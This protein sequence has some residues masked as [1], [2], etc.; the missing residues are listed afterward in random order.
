MGS[1]VSKDCA[2]HWQKCRRSLKTM[3][4]GCYVSQAFQ[5]KKNKKLSG[6]GWGE[7]S[8]AACWVKFSS[9]SLFALFGSVLFL[10]WGN[11]STVVVA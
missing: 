1:K 7:S 6:G 9:C 3:K 11:K 10:S 5:E 8:P 4:E 2:K